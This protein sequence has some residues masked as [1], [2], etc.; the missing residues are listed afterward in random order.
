MPSSMYGHEV[1]P[2]AD[3]VNPGW[4]NH[5]KFQNYVTERDIR[6]VIGSQIQFSEDGANNKTKF[7]PSEAKGNIN[8]AKQTQQQIC[9]PT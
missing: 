9:T 3:A 4:R 6:G 2:K 7:T 8:S 5:D 1:F